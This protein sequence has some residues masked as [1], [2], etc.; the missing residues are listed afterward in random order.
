MKFRIFLFLT[1]TLT[2]LT[3]LLC[4]E[5]LEVTILNKIVADTILVTLPVD[6]TAF[7]QNQNLLF[8]DERG[9]PPR[10]LGIYETKKFT[11]P[12]D[13]YIILNSPLEDYLKKYA[14]A[15]KVKEKGTVTIK[16]LDIWYDTG[17]LFSKRYILNAYTTFRDISGK[18]ISDWTWEITAK[19]PRGKKNKQ[20]TFAEL[21][22][23]FLKK[24]IQVLKN[25]NY[26]RAIYPYIYKRNLTCWVEF[27]T[28]PT[29]YA[30]IPH[31]MLYYPEGQKKRFIRA[32]KLIY[33]RKA[34]NFESIA[35]NGMN[36]LWYQRLDEKL[37]L[38]WNLN[39]NVGIN[40]IN[41]DRVKR[42]E[43]Y[44]IL[45]FNTLV[46]ASIELNRYHRKGIIAGA[47]A[48][49]QV[50]FLPTLANYFEPGAGIY[51]GYVIP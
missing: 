39:V 28:F 24:Q 1:F 29:G 14:A 6:T 45:L 16:K 36:Q 38:R 25:R 20:Q 46:G 34:E 33:Y 44:N 50:N 30:I 51:I 43:Y 4:S 19:P 2:S 3:S 35:I 42:T 13:L 26:S 15:L 23:L 49:F 37:I 21:T 11:L 32:S 9:L 22:D 27:I 48:F 8:T 17:P 40:S 18:I 5:K 12:V 7:S 31:I 47:G 41:P 10:L